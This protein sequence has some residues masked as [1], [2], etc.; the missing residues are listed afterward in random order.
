MVHDSDRS[1][2]ECRVGTGT[3]VMQALLQLL[4]GYDY[5]QLGFEEQNITFILWLVLYTYLW[6][7]LAVILGT[8][9]FKKY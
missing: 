4:F 9:K 7:F 6:Y 1:D 2:A 5:I 3:S 8:H